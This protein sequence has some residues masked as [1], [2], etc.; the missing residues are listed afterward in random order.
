VRVQQRAD[1]ALAGLVAWEQTSLADLRTELG[2][3]D[4]KALK[5]VDTFRAGALADLKALLGRI[6]AGDDGPAPGPAKPAAKPAE[7]PPPPKPV[8]AAQPVPPK[9]VA[10]AGA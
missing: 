5:Q 1:D 4:D 8:Q 7:A 10:K 3:A 2:R 6:R 9:P